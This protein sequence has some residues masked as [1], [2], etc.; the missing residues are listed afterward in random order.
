MARSVALVGFR[1]A[2][3]S[4]VGRALAMALGMECVDVRESMERSWGMSTPLI[5]ARTGEDRFHMA[6]ASAVAGA[7]SADGAVVLLDVGLIENVRVRDVLRR[8]SFVVLL[9]AAPSVT[10]P[11]FSAA[12]LLQ[13]GHE[14]DERR[15]RV[16]ELSRARALAHRS[17]YHMA[18]DASDVG[19]AVQLIASH[20]HRDQAVAR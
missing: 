20:L 15:T 2:E 19:Q 16:F 18:V 10:V 14:E 11:G 8:Q 3:C 7:V 9:D 12:D 17:L 4:T 5:V 1:D 13:D 6:Q